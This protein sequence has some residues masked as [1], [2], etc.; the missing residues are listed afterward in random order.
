VKLESEAQVSILQ[1]SHT[2]TDYVLG[3]FLGSVGYVL[4]CRYL[5]TF[6]ALFCCTDRCLWSI[7]CRL[8]SGWWRIWFT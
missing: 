2:F 4:N 3:T 8:G 7:W 5:D 6:A 1:Y